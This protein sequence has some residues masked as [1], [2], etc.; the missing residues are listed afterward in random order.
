MYQ[1]QPGYKLMF[2]TL[3]AMYSN[4][5]IRVDIAG[6]VESI[7]DI[8]KD[9]LYLCYETF[10]HPSNMVLFI[11]GDVNPQNMIDLVEQHEAKRNKTNQPK[12]ER[13]EIDE[14]I[15][16]NQHNVTEQM[17]LQSPRLMLGFKINHLKKA[18]KN[19]YKEI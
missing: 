16:V 1:E 10:Y 18:R 7:Y 4:H 19:M 8:T 14:P 5:P 17:K 6:S 3:R 15:E 13:A 9:D 2:N 12:I 11:V